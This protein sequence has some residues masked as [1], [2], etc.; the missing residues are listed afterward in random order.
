MAQRMDVFVARQAIFDRNL[1]VYGYE[2]LFRSCRSE[3]FDGADGTLA[4]AQ[5]ITNSFCS[6]GVEK[7]LAG[8][9]AFINFPRDLLI[10]EFASVLPSQTVVIEILE[11]VEPDPEVIAACRSL[12]GRGYLL[13]LDDFIPRE[14][15]DPLAALADII[16]VDF[17]TTPEA[18]R[19]ALIRRYGQDGIRMLAEKVESLEESARAR[20]LGYAY[21]QGY[22]FARPVIVAGRQI[23]SLKLNCLRILQEIHRPELEYG[24]MENLIRRDVS[25]SYKLLRYINS[26]AFAWHSRIESIRQAL[27]L[28]GEQEIRKWVSLVALPDLA[29]DK[30]SELVVSAILRARFCELLAPWAGLPDRKADLFLMGMFSLLDAMMDRPLAELLAELHLAGEVRDVLLGK[31]APDN[32]LAAIYALVRA[33]EGAE[34]DRL[35]ATAARLNV[36]KE[37]IPELYLDAVHWSDRI[38]QTAQRARDSN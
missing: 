27:V 12:K 35:A 15:Y 26:A 10:G 1:N 9:R 37:I 18:E 5:V 36:P 11:S 28:L 38:F 33:Y 19:R 14:C 20:D 17:R 34:W 23:P 6:I 32:R 7:L 8:K 29:L 30:P 2:L 22:F 3:A 13:A 21:F 25:L 4:S 24:Q 31:A 16:K